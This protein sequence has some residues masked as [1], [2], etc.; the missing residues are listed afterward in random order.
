MKIKRIL[1]SFVLVFA[2]LFSVACKD[3]NP[4]E[5]SKAD[6]VVIPKIEEGVFLVGDSLKDIE[7]LLGEGSTS[8]TI[9]WVNEN[10]T[11]VDGLNNCAWKF[12]PNDKSSFNEKTGSS[13]INAR[14]L[15]VPQV[16]ASIVEGQTIYID[17]I[18]DRV[19]FLRKLA[20]I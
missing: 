13:Q 14:R 16:S 20:F 7:I 8:G 19:I 17:A 2:V 4:D 3:K 11:L 5:S 12:V 15:E 9:S 1:F 10:Y 6:P 18:C